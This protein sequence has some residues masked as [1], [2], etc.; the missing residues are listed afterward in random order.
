MNR[1]TV[2]LEE[3]EF[4]H[5]LAALQLYEDVGQMGGLPLWIK[6][7]A[8]NGGRSLPLF[9]GDLQGLRE[10][11]NFTPWDEPTCQ[12]QSHE[13]CMFCQGCGDC[14]EDLDDDDWCPDCLNDL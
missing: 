1:I 11:L 10:R 4:H 6:E 13:D 5:I 9:A 3:P 7:I 2:T 12:H 8:T 14:R